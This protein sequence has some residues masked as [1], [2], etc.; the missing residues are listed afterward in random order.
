[1]Q[2]A[3]GTFDAYFESGDSSQGIGQRRM[4]EAWDSRVGYHDRFACQCG[5]VPPEERGQAL[6]ADFLFAFDDKG[7]VARKVG[8]GFEI[9]FDRVQ[10]GEVLP[11]VVARA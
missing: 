3:R 5:P 11:L 8:V 2:V 4:P 1:M 9:G 6:A 10:M 7:D